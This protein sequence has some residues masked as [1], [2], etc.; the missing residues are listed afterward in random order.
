MTYP[1]PNNVKTIAIIG[2][3]TIG[4]S[5]AAWFL[6]RGATVRA[7]DPDP[8]RERF[9]RAYIEAAWPAL[10]RN[11]G[12]KPGEALGRLSFVNSP[13]EAAEGADFVQENAPERQE[14]KI[15]LLADIDA[16]LP[17]D[18]VIASSTSGFGVSALQ[19]RMRNPGRLVIGHP[20]NPPHLIPL[21]EVVGG[22][23]TDP[24]AEAWAIAFYRAMGKRAIHIRKE[25]P[26]HLA[27]R[28]Q[29]ALWREA[30]H[31][32]AEGVASVAD[33]DDA[34]AYG[35][36]LRWAIMGPHMT[37]NLGGGEGGMPH[38]L[39]QFSGPMES[40]WQTLGTPKLTPE[41]RQK[42]IEGVRE[43]IA[44][45]AHASLADERDRCLLAILD[46]LASQRG[47]K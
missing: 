44:G 7:T 5:W 32:V 40:W 16:A 4:A 24:A 43:E 3:G 23:R 12:G 46:A 10:L 22:G 2:C 26:G 1:D 30:V 15:D 34:I 9:L 33:V 47:S 36:G 45:R 17:P 35:P 27:N 29:A 28:L 19:A 25:V 8:K 21:V 18:R 38:F 39:E 37:F 11:E 14:L 20:F 41:V 31:L 42:L 6:S 13:P